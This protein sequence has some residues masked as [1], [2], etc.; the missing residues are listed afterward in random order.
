MHKYEII[1]INEK[2]KTYR[3]ISWLLLFTNFISLFLITIS[4][5]FNKLGPFIFNLLAAATIF[6]GQYFKR[7]N[8][9]ITYSLAFFIF[10]LAWFNTAYDWVAYINLIFFILEPL[11]NRKLSVR[12][13]NSWII[14]P[15]AISKKILWKEINNA[16]LK[17]DIL[18]LDL[19]NNKLFQ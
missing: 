8:D 6:I 18:T 16:L 17:D 1:L 10:S 13:Y 11:A 14:Y 9:K 7:K 15:S 12:F 19:K 2:E 3:V 4:V 5:D